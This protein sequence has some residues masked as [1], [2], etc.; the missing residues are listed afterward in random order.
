MPPTPTQLR[1]L[2]ILE[3]AMRD[4]ELQIT[5]FQGHLMGAK[6]QGTDADGSRKDWISTGD[7]STFLDNLRTLTWTR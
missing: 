1:R 2:R 6:F 5:E 7:V 4:L 3:E